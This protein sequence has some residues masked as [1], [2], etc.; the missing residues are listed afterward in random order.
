MCLR[1]AWFWVLSSLLRALRHPNDTW[2][3][4]FPV[5]WRTPLDGR[6]R[7][8]LRRGPHGGVRKGAYRTGESPWSRTTIPEPGQGECGLAWWWWKGRKTEAR[9]GAKLWRE[10]TG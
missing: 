9:W 8:W 5:A 6:H 3:A 1:F 7:W 4:A 2:E 10:G